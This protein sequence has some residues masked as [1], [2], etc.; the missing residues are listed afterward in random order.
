MNRLMKIHLI[1]DIKLQVVMNNLANLS[2][3]KYR[4]KVAKDLRGLSNKDLSNILSCTE[5]TVSNYLNE[6]KPFVPDFEKI[7][8]LS[9]KLGLPFSF[10]QSN[11]DKR[12]SDEQI[13]YRSFNRIKAQYRNSAR[14]YSEF[15]IQTL[16]FFD[17]K[18]SNLPKFKGINV[19][20][21]NLIDDPE[22]TALTLR[23]EWKLGMLP[24]KNMIGVLESHGIAVFRLPLEVKEVD[25]FSFY[26]DGRP[27]IFLNTF[28]SPERQRFDAAHELGHIILHSD[29]VNVLQNMKEKE[30]QADRFA[31]SFLMPKDL[32]ISNAPNNLSLQNMIHYKHYWKVSL[33]ALNYNLHKLGLLSEWKYRANTIEFS[34][35]GYYNSEPES[36]ERDE[37][38]LLNKIID[39][40]LKKEGRNFHQPL[41]FGFQIFDEITFKL[42][43]NKIRPKL[44]VLT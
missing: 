24:I 12:V 23:A 9:E 5:V 42:T 6:N 4:L 8:L 40:L 16:E 34:K 2:F 33:V 25:A 29:D 19:D 41:D 22:K 11:Y 20:I 10:F 27:I 14:A 35:N 37:P 36:V 3:S 32:F 31:A 26:H 43:S 39:I 30:N 7:V 28:K 44:R 18:I 1:L 15:A 13:F 21:D 17:N 38:I